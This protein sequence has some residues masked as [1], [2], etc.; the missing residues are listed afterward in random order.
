MA[1]GDRVLNGRFDYRRIVDIARLPMICVY[2]KPTDYPDKY[3]ARLW[4]GQYPTRL[5]AVA[6]TLDD[7]KEKIPPN[8]VL[9]PRVEKDDPTIIGSWL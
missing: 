9:I 5:V 1:D 7:I 3:V 8:M 2:E 4:D 6:D